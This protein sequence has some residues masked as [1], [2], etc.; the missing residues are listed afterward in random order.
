MKFS[1][2]DLAMELDIEDKDII[3]FEQDAPHGKQIDPGRGCFPCCIVWTPLPVVS[4]L[5]PFVGHVE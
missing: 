3:M 4:W 1:Y 2:T 5:L